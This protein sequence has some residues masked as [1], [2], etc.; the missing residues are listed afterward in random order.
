MIKVHV[1]E[2]AHHEEADENEGRG[3]CNCRHGEE[4]RGKENRNCKADHH[5]EGGQTGAA[6]GG[7]ARSAFNVGRRGARAEA[8][9]RDRGDGVGHQR[10]AQSRDVAFL[11]NHAGLHRHADYGA[12]RIEEVDKEE[13]HHH[14]RHIPRKDVVV[15][16]LHGD[17]RNRRRQRSNALDVGD[18]ERDSDERDGENAVKERTAHFEG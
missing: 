16:K 17:G 2:S 5:R 4:Q 1:D 18:A 3:R 13:G 12:D 9:T 11:V 15:F 6:A 7:D 10:L 14:D 8:G